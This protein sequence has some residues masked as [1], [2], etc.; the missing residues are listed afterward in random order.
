[1]ID[2]FPDDALRAA[3]AS[4]DEKI[5]QSM[6]II[7]EALSGAHGNV[8]H[9]FGMYSSGNDSA[10]STHLLSRHPKFS[11]AV[12]IDTTIAIPEAQEHG[13]KVARD[14]QWRLKEYRAPVSYREIVKKYGFPG[15]GAHGVTYARLK[16]RC[17]RQLVRE[18]KDKWKDRIG[19][20]TGVRLSESKRRM[21]HVERI[22]REGAKLW[23]AP[24]INWNDDD[25][26]A[27]MARHSIPRNPV[28]EL[29]CISGECLCGCFAEQKEERF[30]INLHFPETGKMLDELEDMARAA[31]V[32]CKWGTRPPGGRKAASAGGMLCAD[33]NQRSI[34]DVI[35]EAA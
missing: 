25:K 16:E 10:C 29:V 6:E 12:M 18:H 4:L 24:I 31:G 34:F 3:N 2:L 8:T 30:E 35:G 26:I 27:Y 5:K 7:D 1:M 21:G 17:V 13:R 15:P 22:Q 9:L 11:G 23:I 33:C 28:T 32:H 20:V 14:F 19:L